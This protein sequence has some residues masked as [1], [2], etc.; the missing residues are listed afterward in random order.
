VERIA[1]SPLFRHSKHYPA[2]LRHVVDQTL[3]GRA[4]QLKER[5]LGFEVFGRDP[6][7]DTSSDPVVRNSACEVRKRISQFYQESGHEN[8]IR[9]DLPAGSYVPEFSFPDA[10]SF[11]LIS[12]TQVPGLQIGIIPALPHTTSWRNLLSKPMQFAAG[13]LLLVAVAAAAF[14]YKP[15]DPVE[16]FWGSVWHAS[17]SVTIG[18]S[19]GGG[20]PA[21]PQSPT[22]SALDVSRNDRIAYADALT[23]ARL[24][25]LLA[26]HQKKYEIRAAATFTLEDLRKQPSIL[27]GGFN[28]QWSMRLEDRLRFTLKRDP[29]THLLYIQDAQNLSARNWTGNPDQPYAQMTEDYAIISRVMDPRTEEMVVVVAG[30]GKDGTMAGG[31][32]LTTPRFLKELS[33]RAP[34]DWEHKNAQVVL[35]VEIVNGN[36][37]RPRILAAQFW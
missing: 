32:F 11:S 23:L 2:L 14:L 10:G 17:D 28:N 37:A 15:E 33:Q 3:E 9:I 1:I 20:P 13:G 22:L 4:G 7:Y 26:G 34:R 30:M 25:G 31:E 29:E 5:V 6:D 19:R 24:T 35:G 27:I 12:E 36:P 8:E 21:Q 16:Q 18:V